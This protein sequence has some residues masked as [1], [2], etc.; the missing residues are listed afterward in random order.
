MRKVAALGCTLLA[1]WVGVPLLALLP[2]PKMLAQQEAD[3]PALFRAAPL[4]ALIGTVKISGPP[5]WNG[6]YLT[7][8]WTVGRTL[9]LNLALDGWKYVWRGGNGEGFERGSEQLGVVCRRFSGGFDVCNLQTWKPQ[10]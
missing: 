5:G 7:R 1:L 2:H 9:P 8:G 10:P 3:A 4:A 6:R